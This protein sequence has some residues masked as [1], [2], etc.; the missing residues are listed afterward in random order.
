MDSAVFTAFVVAKEI[1]LNIIAQ[2]FGMNKKYRWEE[3]LVLKEKNLAGI[4]NDWS[5]KFVYIFYFGSLVFINFAHHETMD[6]IKYLQKLEKNINSTS[7]LTFRDD[8]KLIIKQG[9]EPSVNF[10]NMVAES[11]KDYHLEIISIILAKSVALEKIENDIDKLFDD[12]ENIVDLLDKGRFNISDRRLAKTSAMILRYKF[13]SISYIMLLDKPDITWVKVE[14][15]NLYTELS[16][17]FELE[18]RYEVIHQKSETLMDIT[19]AFTGLTHATRGTRL[20]WM[21]IILI[22]LEIV[23]SLLEKII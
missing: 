11:F 9:V 8:F 3:P 13:N 4:I 7:L 12:I 23:L 22:A 10:F 16:Q 1:N 19:Q 6:V 14:A 2:H 17:L 20:E 18:E 21:I 5:H 15:G